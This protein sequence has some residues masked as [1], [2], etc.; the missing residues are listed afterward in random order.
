[1]TKIAIVGAGFSGA[2]IAN[3]LAKANFNITVFESRHH[4]GG[5]C[6]TKRDQNT[7]IMV[8][9]YGPHIFHTNNKSIWEYVNSF[10]E[11]APYVN[12]VKA[13]SRGKV[14]S[15]PINLLTINA[16]YGTSFSPCQAKEFLSHQSLPI[17]DPSNFE[18]QALAYVGR[19][20]YEA[21]FKGYTI[22]QWGISP[23]ELPASILKR[24][25]IRFNYDDNYYSS[26]YQGIPINGYTRIIEKML[27]HT[28]I[29]VHLSTSWSPSKQSYY[30]FVFY[31]GPLDAWFGYKEGDLSYRTLDFEK[32]ISQGDYQGNAV[33]NYCD[34]NVSWTRISEHKHF[35]PWETHKESIAYKEY[36]RTWTRGDIPYYPVRLAKD[37]SILLTYEDMARNLQNTIFVGRLATYRYLDMHIAIEEAL[38]AANT[39]LQCLRCNKPVPAFPY[40]LAS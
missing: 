36:S 21:F 14:Y 35:A 13:V 10:D 39:F 22:K 8:H 32:I 40:E 38:K 15:L 33:I 17:K 34:H 28:N 3:E 29:D 19:D 23:T 12:R 24:L 20:L 25:P 26:I 6:Y 31:T 4:V 7:G 5:N 37:K 1:M 16:F 2:V 18:E 11:F 9:E 30:D 27:S